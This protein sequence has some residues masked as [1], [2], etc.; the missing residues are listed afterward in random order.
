M[1]N[2]MDS[3]F[4]ILAQKNRELADM[5]RDVAGRIMDECYRNNNKNEEHEEIDSS[6]GER[7][8]TK[9]LP[10]I[11][12]RLTED[13]PLFGY[14][15]NLIPSKYKGGCHPNCLVLSFDKWGAEKG[16]KGRANEM[17]SYWLECNDINRNS[18]VITMAWDELD[19]N[20]NYLKNFNAHVS[21]HKTICVVLVTSEGFSIQYLR[22]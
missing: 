9:I 18:L 5:F 19:F 3:V 16:F 11:L 8:P 15:I 20:Q 13:V 17:I 21:N 14:P 22:P 7:I 4:D 2:S 6:F 10:K 12:S 1:I